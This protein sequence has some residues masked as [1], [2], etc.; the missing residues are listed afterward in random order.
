[1]GATA[2]RCYAYAQGETAP[3][4]SCRLLLVIKPDK[5]PQ[6]YARVK[7]QADSVPGWARV[8]IPL[9]QS[10]DGKAFRAAARLS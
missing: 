10:K 3:A 5:S 7:L 4:Q 2:W 9:A 6:E 1:M 8:A